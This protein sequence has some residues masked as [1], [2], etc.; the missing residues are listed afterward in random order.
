MSDKIKISFDDLN[1]S[2]VDD[3]LKRQDLLNR[4]HQHQ[5]TVAANT[6]QAQMI[7]HAPR[8]G[9]FRNAIVYMFL[10]GLL[11][12]ILGWAG[13]EVT[14]YYEEQNENSKEIF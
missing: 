11:G 9:F 3:D 14:Q 2:K 8:G 6:T 12:G 1:S 10:F 4:M 7:Q 13:G 5:Q